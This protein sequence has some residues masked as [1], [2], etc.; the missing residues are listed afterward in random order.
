MN[1]PNEK[2]DHMDKKTETGGGA[3]DTLLAKGAKLNGTL[4][5]ENGIKIEGEVEGVIETNGTLVIGKEGLIKAEIKARDC[6]IGGKVIGNITA[7]NKIELEKGASLTGDVKCRGI[8]I[9]N[10]VFFEGHSK[11]AAAHEPG[12]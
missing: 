8:I 5:A 3:I 10:D 2:R 12:K 9:D 11:M 1:C 4:K 6:I 7:A